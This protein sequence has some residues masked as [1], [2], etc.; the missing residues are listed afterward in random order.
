MD[1]LFRIFNTGVMPMWLLMAVAPR[2]R[3]T[4]WLLRFPLFPL[5]VAGGYLVLMLL[6]LLSGGEE[7]PQGDFFS[8]DGVAALFSRKEV[9]L[10]G[11]L[12]YLAFDLCV[13]MWELRDSQRLGIAH[14]WVL[15]CLF[16]TLMLG[17]IGFLLY[18]GVRSIHRVRNAKQLSS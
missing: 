5:V 13:G 7:Q 11:W 9:V 14:Y 12:H 3:V 1:L 10:V 4:Q 15:P 2:W 18:W 8:L 17:P 6:G 16:F